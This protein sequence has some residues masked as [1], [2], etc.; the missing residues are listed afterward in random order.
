[1]AFAVLGPIPGACCNSSAVAEFKS[2]R[3]RRGE[4]FRVGAGLR[5]EK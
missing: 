2:T 5:G 4:A 1:M 3:M